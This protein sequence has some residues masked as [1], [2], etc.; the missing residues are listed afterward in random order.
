MV[1]SQVTDSGMTLNAVPASIRVTVTT[2]G[3][4]A[5]TTRV[6]MACRAVTI[7]QATGTGSVASWGIEAWPPRPMTLIWNSSQEASMVPARQATRPDGIMGV[8]WMAKARSTSPWVLSRPSDEHHPGA[9]VPLLARLEHQHHPPGQL[10]P[11][12]RQQA[13]RADQHGDVGVV[14]AGVHLA[15]DRGGEIEPGVLRHFQG[16]HVGP[17]QGGRSGPVAVEGGDHRGGGAAG[18]RLQTEAVERL[19]H[20]LLGHGQVQPGL[21]VAVDAPAQLDRLARPGRPLRRPGPGPAAGWGMGRRLHPVVPWSSVASSVRLL[22]VRGRRP[23]G[24][25]PSECPGLPGHGDPEAEDAGFDGGRARSA[26]GASARRGG[27]SS[28]ATEPDRADVVAAN[29]PEMME[30]AQGRPGGGGRARGPPPGWRSRSSRRPGGPS[31]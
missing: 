23:W 8:M 15:V 24:E 13:G 29:S 25:G 6:T 5:G 30:V 31:G 18:G 2:A 20:G 26:A 19:E 17:Q 11:V 1:P 16:V 7:S 9:A 28:S 22:S 27:R 12:R 4:K 21:R 3:S 14:A 10:R